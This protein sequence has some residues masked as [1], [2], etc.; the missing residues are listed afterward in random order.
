VLWKWPGAL[1]PICGGGQSVVSGVYDTLSNRKFVDLGR[2][3]LELD[4]NGHSL[5]LVPHVDTERQEDLRNL[6]RLLLSLTP[7]VSYTSHELRQTLATSNPRVSGRNYKSS[8]WG[9]T[10]LHYSYI[11]AHNQPR[12]EFADR[13]RRGEEMHGEIRGPQQYLVSSSRNR[14]DLHSEAQNITG[15][16]L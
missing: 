13:K 14:A 2:M 5:I 12:S 15:V 9:D 10:R 6:V 4:V 11:T 1:E 3:L 7:A 8:F 16:D